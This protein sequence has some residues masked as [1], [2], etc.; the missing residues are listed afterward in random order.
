MLPSI[1]AVLRGEVVGPQA[2]R[3]TRLEHLRWAIK[4]IP[5]FRIPFQPFCQDYTTQFISSRIPED[6]RDDIP[7]H[8]QPGIL[9]L[10]ALFFRLVF[11]PSGLFSLLAEPSAASIA[12]ESFTIGPI[13]RSM[14]TSVGQFLK[15]A[16]RS[17]KHLRISLIK[18]PGISTSLYRLL[19]DLGR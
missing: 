4:G 6:W 18:D 11:W 8:T 12:M 5:F 7:I 1:W 19:R 13:Y 16:A 2:M 14:L 17:I 10:R 3:G 9:F 15:A